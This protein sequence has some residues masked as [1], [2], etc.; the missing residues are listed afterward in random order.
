LSRAEPVVKAF[1]IKRYIDQ[2]V[3]PDIEVTWTRQYLCEGRD[4]DIAKALDLFGS[5]D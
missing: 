1:L 5:G 4:P 2:A 3:T